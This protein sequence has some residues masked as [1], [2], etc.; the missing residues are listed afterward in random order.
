[1][2]ARNS[3][4]RRE[5]GRGWH[6]KR[7]RAI[8]LEDRAQPECG[9][10][11]INRPSLVPRPKLP[12][13]CI[14]LD[15]VLGGDDTSLLNDVVRWILLETGGTWSELSLHNCLSYPTCLNT[16]ANMSPAGLSLPK[17]EDTRGPFPSIT[18]PGGSQAVCDRARLSLEPILS[19]AL[20]RGRAVFPVI[21]PCLRD[22]DRAGG[23][24][25][26]AHREHGEFNF[27]F[28]DI[29]DVSGTP[30]R[31]PH[32]PPRFP[33]SQRVN[34]VASCI[35]CLRLLGA[36]VFYRGRAVRT[37]AYRVCRGTDLHGR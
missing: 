24:L 23:E 29:E 13:H 11:I 19:S 22:A 3:R 8:Y 33:S 28:V 18:T 36:R 30:Q 25:G 15:R 16:C 12:T 35:L 2:R 1:M 10:P 34:Q 9:A 7:T 37:V 14:Q 5:S 4:V 20:P 21:P 6:F 26:K 27:S 32:C 17:S 31:F